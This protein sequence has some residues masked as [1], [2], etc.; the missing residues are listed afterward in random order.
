[1]YVKRILIDMIL[2]RLADLDA[3]YP[4]E[5][6]QEMITYTECM[7][8]LGIMTGKEQIMWQR[9]LGDLIKAKGGEGA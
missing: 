1:M 6:I 3:T 8:D 7:R 5:M 9:K 2:D 4:A